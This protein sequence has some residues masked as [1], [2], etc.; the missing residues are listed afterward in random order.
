MTVILGLYVL[1]IIMD[2]YNT[3]VSSVPLIDRMQMRQSVK[4]V[5]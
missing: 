3:L 4:N 2:Q 1:A 5:A